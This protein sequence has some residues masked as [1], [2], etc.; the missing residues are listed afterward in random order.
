MKVFS[1]IPLMFYPW[2]KSPGTDSC[3]CPST[4]LDI[5]EKINDIVE[6]INIS[7]PC[8]DSNSRQSSL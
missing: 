3:V 8:Q 1:L 5:V 4:T 6:K 7:S 2:E